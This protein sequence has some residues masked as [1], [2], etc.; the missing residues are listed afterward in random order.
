MYRDLAPC[1]LYIVCACTCIV[2]YNLKP[3]ARDLQASNKNKKF[4]MVVICRTNGGSYVL[5][6]LDGSMSNLWY[7]TFQLILYLPWDVWSIPVTKLTD[8][9]LGD[10]EEM[11][12][13]SKNPLN[14]LNDDNES[15]W[16]KIQKFYIPLYLFILISYP[17]PFISHRHSDLSTIYTK[18]KKK[19]VKRDAFP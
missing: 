16:L 2:T 18:K 9:P 7:A 6:E 10:L 12:H 13:G 8:V 3:T 5:G 19:K 1:T 17:L 4:S 14:V 15:F 11:T